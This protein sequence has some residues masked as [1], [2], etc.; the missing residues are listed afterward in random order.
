[1]SE[2]YQLYA[3][4]RLSRSRFEEFLAAPFP[5]PSGDPEVLAWLSEAEYYGPRYTPETIRAQVVAGNTTVDAYVESLAAPGAWGISAPFRNE[6]DDKTQTWTLAIL[7]FS[8]NYDDYLAAVAVFRECAK[9]KDL[10]SDDGLLVYG[11][12]FGNGMP[13]AL[14][15]RMGTSAFIVE[16]EATPLIEQADAVMEELTAQGAALA[17]ENRAE[18]RP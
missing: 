2:P 10:P 15:I 17:T 8:E 7:D 12:L 14:R 16:D 18:R 3:R 5:D 4:I 1:M 6:Y 11:Y 9:Y 13:L